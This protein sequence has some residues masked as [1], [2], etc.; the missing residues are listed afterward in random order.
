MPTEPR[1]AKTRSITTE[2]KSTCGEIYITVG[3]NDN[4]SP[5]EIF[6]RFGKAGGCAS[7]MADGFARLCSYALRSGMPIS[8]AIK[9]FEGQSCQ[10]GTENN[11]LNQIAIVLKDYDPDAIEVTND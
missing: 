6:I 11:C 9:A 8:R 10:Y 1:P 3:F 7:A 5:F 2:V 4:N